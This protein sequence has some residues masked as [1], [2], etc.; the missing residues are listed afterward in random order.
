MVPVAVSSRVAR[1]RTALIPTLAA[2]GFGAE[3]PEDLLGWVPLPGRR[4]VVVVEGSPE[5][6][7][8]GGLRTE[9][10]DLVAVAVLGDSCPS[11][12]R[13]ALR[14][15]YF[16]VAPEAS[17]GGITA[18]LRAALDGQVLLPQ[19]VIAG[20]IGGVVPS[21]ADAPSAPGVPAWPAFGVTAG[22]EPPSP[23]NAR[24]QPAL[25]GTEVLILRRIAQ[26]DT[27][28]RIASALGV[29]ERTVRRRMRALFTKLGVD[30]RVQA[31]VYAAGRGLAAAGLASGP[32][33]AG[34]AAA[35]PGRD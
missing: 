5:A 17:A 29:S 32:P 7:A 28:R 19:T 24:A 26:G 35:L 12:F 25:D 22:G 27:D 13:E 33:A 20:L 31:G 3:E 34:G 11:A 30:T 15:G 6:I 8:I 14:A 4:A 2:A 16:P 23:P 18:V 21:G 9:V 10:G 1:I